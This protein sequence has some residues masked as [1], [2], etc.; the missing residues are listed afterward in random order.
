MNGKIT[1]L[2]FLCYLIYY[3]A[4]AQ[5]TIYSFD[6]LKSKVEINSLL[7]KRAELKITYAQKEKLAAIYGLFDPYGNLSATYTNNTKLPVTLIPSEI[8]GGPSGSFQEVQFGVQYTTNFNAYA[9]IK[10]I[11]LQGWENL[12]LSKLNILINESDSK[13][14]IKN[15]IENVAVVYHNI[16][17][18]QEQQKALELNLLAADSL[19]QFTE[20]RFKNGLAS[21]QDLNEGKINK[22]NIEE[23]LKQ[24][25]FQI[26]QQYNALKILCDFSDNEDIVIRQPSIFDYSIKKVEIIPNTLIT[27]NAKYRVKLAK[28]NYKSSK[29]AFTPSLSVFGAYQVQQYNTRAIFIDNNIDWISSTYIGAKLSIPLPTHKS[30]AHS[31]KAKYDYLTSLNYY[32]QSKKHMDI[33]YRQLSIEYEKALSQLNNN[34]EVYNLRKETYQKNLINYKEGIAGIEL[35]INSFNALI[36]SQY[37][38]ISSVV[39]LMLVVEKININNKTF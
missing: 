2:S 36:N 9:E 33:N 38:Y 12:R 22:L 20:N 5:I 8:M 16:L 35:A 21:T 30:F 25:S 17:N 14:T 18:L 10:L 15:L 19:F 28:S 6:D 37:N 27:E 3:H 29:Y 7:L 1:I 26:S 23:S 39:N 11:N 4:T 24:I 32:E 13:I 31:S 34:L